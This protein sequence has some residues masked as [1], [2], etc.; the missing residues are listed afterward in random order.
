V[1]PEGTVN[2]H[3]TALYCITDDLLKAVGHREDAHYGHPV[4]CPSLV[5][6]I[7][8][9]VG[10]EPTNKGFAVFRREFR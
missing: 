8:A 2:D 9:A 7:K 3:C 1:K 10:I 6:S 5:V 4:G